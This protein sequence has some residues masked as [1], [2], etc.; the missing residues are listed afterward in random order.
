MAA[1]F[2]SYRAPDAVPAE[3]LANE[4]RSRGHDVWLDTWEISLGDSVIGKM[5]EG[6]AKAAYLLL[7]CSS[8][9]LDSQWVSREWMSTLVRQLRGVDVKILPVRLTGGESPAILADIKHADITKDWD[10][11]VRGLCAV[12]R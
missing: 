5:N 10:S 3:R 6:L 11:G 9:G 12:I 1:I 7:C 8:S 4:L 2:V